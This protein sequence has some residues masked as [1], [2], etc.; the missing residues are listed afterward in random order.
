MLRRCIRCNRQK[1][2][3]FTTKYLLKTREISNPKEINNSYIF[4]HFEQKIQYKLQIITL[5]SVHFKITRIGLNV[6]VLY[7]YVIKI[8]S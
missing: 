5:Y 2:R 4:C 3:K 8:L 6:L 1:N 7:P